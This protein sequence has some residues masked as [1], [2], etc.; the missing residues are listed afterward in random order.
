MVRQ[1]TYRSGILAIAA[2]TLLA[3]CTSVSS[4]LTDI[5]F[6]P[7]SNSER[8]L[9]ES[10]E[11][12]LA[13]SENVP[14]PLSL[15]KSR[16]LGLQDYTSIL[17]GPGSTGTK[18]ADF[19]LAQIGNALKNETS[20]YQATYSADAVGDNFYHE[21][22]PS[23]T[24][25]E[26]ENGFRPYS[27]IKL[28]GFKFD[29]MVQSRSGNETDVA[30]S[31]CAIVLPGRSDGFF[32]VVPVSYQ[33]QYS[34]AKLIG[35]DLMS[36]FGVDVLNPWEIVTNPLTGKGYSGLPADTDLDMEIAVGFRY[37]HYLGNGEVT[38]TMVGPQNFTLKNVPVTGRPST[39]YFPSYQK[40]FAKKGG[41]FE[42]TCHADQSVEAI[43]DLRDRILALSL[44]DG[45]RM[46]LVSGARNYASA[47]RANG[48]NSGN[49]NFTLKVAVTELDDYGKRVEEISSAFDQSKGDARGAIS[50][51][52]D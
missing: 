52:F 38:S 35:F 32:Y 13:F 46:Q 18:I 5:V 3:A 50:S 27:D 28:A 31:I 24:A 6:M 17:A 37:L 22:K 45:D 7:N 11:I 41:D 20:R 12:Q 33:M 25:G 40:F 43:A 9:G 2:S 16:S 21:D 44:T 10:V 49:G 8:Q 15:S 34:K 47:P 4:Q 30:M 19:A 23:E 1:V 36:P 42:L 48:P 14:P 26:I 39:G 29:R 51:W